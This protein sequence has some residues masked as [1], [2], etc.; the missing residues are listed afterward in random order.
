MG[1]AALLLLLRLVIR[2]ALPLDMAPKIIVGNLIVSLL[3]LLFAFAFLVKKMSFKETVNVPRAYL[4]AVLFAG[5]CTASIFYSYDFPV[6]LQA[7]IHLIAIIFFVMAVMGLL[8]DKRLHRPTFHIFL[9]IA[10]LAS[11]WAVI[12]YKMLISNEI[13]PATERSAAYLINTKRPPSY[14]GWPN[15]LAGYLIM[16]LPLNWVLGFVAKGNVRK[17]VYFTVAALNTVVLYLTLTVASWSSL[18]VSVCLVFF[19]IRRDQ[20]IRRHKKFIVTIIAICLVL[21]GAVLVKRLITMRDSTVSSFSSRQAYTHNA[22]LLVRDHPFIGNGWNSFD[23]ITIPMVKNVDERSSHVHNSYLQVWAEIGIIGLVFFL[24]FVGLLLRDPGKTFAA[25]DEKKKW[26]YAG[27]WAGAAACAID[28]IF[29]FTMIKCE[30][31]AYWW[32]LAGVLLVLRQPGKL[33]GFQLS[34]AKMGAACLTIIVAAWFTFRL[35]VGEH[36]YFKAMYLLNTGS[37]EAAEDYFMEAYRFNPWDRKAFYGQAL[38]YCA[39]FNHTQDTTYLI[40]AKNAVQE[41]AKQH[42]L[43]RETS[44]LLEEIDP[45]MKQLNLDQGNGSPAH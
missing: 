27:L 41:A 8:E 37:P 13:A 40:L 26:V 24:V 44:G 15:L 39:L 17:A 43:K 9:L 16:V 30:L 18:F 33:Q 42:T 1:A 45:A 19:F 2:T 5:M 38:T 23:T 11:A 32:F 31:A 12:Q 25:L 10:V 36:D 6:T 20:V 28:N 35:A 22:L 4:W 14:F 29:S 34:R 21:A 3:F 7:A